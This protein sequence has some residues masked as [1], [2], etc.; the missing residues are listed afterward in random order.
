MSKAPRSRAWVEQL[1]ERAEASLADIEHLLGYEEMRDADGAVRLDAEGKPVMASR[2]SE[3]SRVKLNMALI[4]MH[5]ESPKNDSGT[6]IKFEISGEVVK[7]AIETAGQSER[8]SI[9][10]LKP[11]ALALPAANAE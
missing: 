11:V 9:L 6:S 3:A 2:C 1:R 5:P 10:D 4:G 8:A 7:L